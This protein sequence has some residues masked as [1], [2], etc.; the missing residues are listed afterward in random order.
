MTGYIEIELG[1]E[2]RRLKFGNY[3]ILKLPE[4]GFTD[5]AKDLNEVDTANIVKMLPV[6]AILIY[7]GIIC[8]DYIDGKP[9]SVTQEQVERWIADDFDFTQIESIMQ[10][11]L[12]SKAYGNLVG[13]AEQ[14]KQKLDAAN[15]VVP[16]K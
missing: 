8:Q 3:A 5:V 2:V 4:L 11:F 15:K 6:I 16:K 7:A 9:M 13:K 1:G 10:C 14:A 12:E